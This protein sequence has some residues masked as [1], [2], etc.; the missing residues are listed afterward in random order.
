M[1]LASFAVVVFLTDC[2]AFLC[3]RGRIRID[4]WPSLSRS[5]TAA[6]WVVYGCVCASA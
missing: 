3:A 2:G 6:L 4:L 1:W 5:K